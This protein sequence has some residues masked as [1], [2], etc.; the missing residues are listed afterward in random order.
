MNTGIKR[1]VLD[2]PTRSAL[3]AIAQ[4]Y[5]TPM[6]VVAGVLLAFAIAE[7]ERRNRK[8]VKR[9]TFAQKFYQRLAHERL[10]AAQATREKNK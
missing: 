4:E 10:I 1:F 6:Q 9:M 5:N 3:A 7:H 2:T 8:L